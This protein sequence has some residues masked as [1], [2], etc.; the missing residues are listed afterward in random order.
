MNTFEN[1]ANEVGFRNRLESMGAKDITYDE[2]TKKVTATVNGQRYLYDTSGL[3]NNNGTLVGSEQD[4]NKIV[5]NPLTQV[6]GKGVQSGV[7]VG[8][9]E[10]NNPMY[11]GQSLGTEGMANVGGNWYGNENYLNKFISGVKNNYEDPY[12]KQRDNIL[13]KLI[14][15]K[16]FS[17]NPDNDENLQNAMKIARRAAMRSEVDRGQGGSFGM[18]YAAS[19]AANSLIPQYEDKAYEKN[20]NER[21]YLASLLGYINDATNADMNAHS[22]NQN[23]KNIDRDYNSQQEQFGIANNFNKAQFAEQIRQFNE[24]LTEEQAQFKEQM[25]LSWA[26]Q[27]LSENAYKSD[28]EQRKFEQGLNLFL[29]TGYVPYNYAEILGLPAGANTLDAAQFV[30]NQYIDTEKLKQNNNDGGG[31]PLLAALG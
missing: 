9:D 7:S 1:A 27:K 5:S 22:I 10:F 18:E 30:H 24:G 2:G 6:R 25:L 16:E 21:G 4:I 17:Y 12:K 28:E 19:Q 20:M 29:A 14:N 13:S 15:Q 26:Q 23:Q 8:Y 31:D 3:K 11:N